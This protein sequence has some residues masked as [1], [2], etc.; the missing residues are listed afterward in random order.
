MLT[1]ISHAHG[2]VF[3]RKEE[4]ERRKVMNNPVKMKQLMKVVSSICSLVC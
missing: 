4:E 3:R 1:I 2:Y